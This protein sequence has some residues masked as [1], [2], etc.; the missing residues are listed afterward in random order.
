MITKTLRFRAFACIRLF[1]FFFFFCIARSLAL[2]VDHI[3]LTFCII[4]CLCLLN[5]YFHSLTHWLTFLV[6]S[7]VSIVINSPSYHPIFTLKQQYT[8]PEYTRH[9]MPSTN[10]ASP[11]SDYSDQDDVMSN[12]HD[13]RP[14]LIR[15]FRSRTMLVDVNINAQLQTI[16][17][18]IGLL[19]AALINNPKN[20]TYVLDT[21]ARVHQTMVLCLG[22]CSEIGYHVSWIHARLIYI[23]GILEAAHACLHCQVSYE[24]Y[25]RDSRYHMDLCSRNGTTPSKPPGC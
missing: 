16:Y 14:K 11:R 10:T 18:Q 20:V 19:M 13:N 7:V 17:D 1:F 23:R 9:I 24:T 21:S 6:S 12:S 5:H 4:L 25:L 3:L 2:V 15:Q 8:R 22:R